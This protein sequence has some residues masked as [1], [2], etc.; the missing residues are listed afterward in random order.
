MRPRISI[1]GSV[2]P[3]VC[4]CVRPLAF[5]RNRRKWRFQPARRILLPVRACFLFFSP[6]SSFFFFLFSR[7]TLVKISF[8][9]IT[10][11][12]ALRS[13]LNVFLEDQL[14][15]WIQGVDSN[16]WNPP[17]TGTKKKKDWILNDSRYFCPSFCSLLMFLFHGNWK[18]HQFFFTVFMIQ[19]P[20]RRTLNRCDEKKNK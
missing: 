20:S 19:N 7:H 5:K 9:L 14:W 1:R 15:D 13:G 3:S 18:E 11:F 2:C 12:K 6:S 16:D 4:P 10:G 8:S 17:V